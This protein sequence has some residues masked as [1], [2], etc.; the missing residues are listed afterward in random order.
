MSIMY[1]WTNEIK[2]RLKGQLLYDFQN[3][4]EEKVEHK[5]PGDASDLVFDQKLLSILLN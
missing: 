4:N 2:T 1:L 5:K 3:V